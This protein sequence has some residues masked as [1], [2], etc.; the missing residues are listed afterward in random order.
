METYQIP[1]LIRKL[2]PNLTFREYKQ[3]KLEPGFWKKEI[4]VCEECYL[5]VCK[6]IIESGSVD[7]VKDPKS[8]VQFFGT[9]PL[10]P[11][12]ISQSR[13]VFY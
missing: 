12:T 6:S 5:S 9:G 11:Q 4:I 3:L 10:R 13:E 2:H 8:K 7:G 1:G